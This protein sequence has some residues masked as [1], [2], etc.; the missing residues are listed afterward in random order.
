MAIDVYITR[1]QLRWAGHVSRMPYHRL[2]RKMLSSW[3]RAKRPR[4]APKL[5]YGRMLRKALKKVG[6]PAEEWQFAAS[7]REHWRSIYNGYIE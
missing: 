3:V 5:T 4:G 6:V 7:D 2:P 1:S